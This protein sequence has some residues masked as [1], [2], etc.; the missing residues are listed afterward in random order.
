MTDAFKLITQDKKL[1]QFKQEV[2]T[3]QEVIRQAKTQ[4]QK[5]LNYLVAYG[6]R[7]APEILP[8]D[9]EIDM[10]FVYGGHPCAVYYSDKKVNYFY[11]TDE[12]EN[13]LKTKRGLFLIEN[14]DNQYAKNQK[15]LFKNN[16]YTLYTNY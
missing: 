2:T 16:D 5:E 4:P 6:E 13:A 12:F 14:G 8:P 11:K 3:R 9:E 7:Q 15:I 1:F 10:T